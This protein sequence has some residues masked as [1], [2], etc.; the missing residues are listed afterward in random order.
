MCPVREIVSLSSVEPEQFKATMRRIASTVTVVTSKSGPA[1]NGMTATAVCSV[2]AT[3]PCILVVVNQTNRSHA[4]IEDAGIFAVNVL[5]E[6]QEFLAQHFAQKSDDPFV[7][8]GYRCGMTGAPILSGCV[9]SLECV[10]ESQTRSGTHSIFVGRV[11]SAAERDQRP[12]L[13][14][15]SRF[16]RLER[17]RLL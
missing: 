7:D 14:T 5:S 6:E 17:S 8:V 16:V 2:S 1:M 12:L 9:A 15:N 10:V 3:P 11:V 4:L 13:H